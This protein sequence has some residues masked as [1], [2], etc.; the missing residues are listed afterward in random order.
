MSTL[1]LKNGTSVLH[2]ARRYGLIQYMKEHGRIAIGDAAKVLGVDSYSAAH[3]HV[4]VL[5]RAKFVDVEMEPHP[6][7]IN[8][9]IKILLLTDTGRAAFE[10]QRRAFKELAAA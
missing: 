10:A 2:D 6:S 3:R 7:G 8:R 9:I 4:D 1:T 5:A